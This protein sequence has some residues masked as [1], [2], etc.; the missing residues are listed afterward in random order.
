M[1]AQR[2]FQTTGITHPVTQY[3]ILEDMNLQQYRFENL[4]SCKQ[5]FENINP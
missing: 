1:K 4:I 5:Y 3:Y 2:S